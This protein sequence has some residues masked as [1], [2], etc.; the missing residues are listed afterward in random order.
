LY[1][2]GS[3]DE[4]CIHLE[5]AGEEKKSLKATIPEASGQ[6]SKDAVKITVSQTPKVTGETP[7]GLDDLSREKCIE[8]IVNYLKTAGVIR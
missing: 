1:P 8:A 6:I 5:T 4:I 7:A 2:D 3:F